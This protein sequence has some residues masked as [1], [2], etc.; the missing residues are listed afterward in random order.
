MSY[1]NGKYILPPALLKK[2][3]QYVQGASIYIPLTD[4]IPPRRRRRDSALLIR[5]AEI[6][7]R[8]LSGVPS[9]IFDRRQKTQVKLWIPAEFSA[10]NR[11]FKAPDGDTSAEEPAE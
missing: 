5:N 9:H 6:L 1:L 2:V 11:L 8:F 7:R 10:E 3:Q 4:P